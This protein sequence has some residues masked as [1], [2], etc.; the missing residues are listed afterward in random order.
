MC[1]IVGVLS[2]EPVSTDL[3]CTMRDRLEHRG[4]DH[5]GLW[6]S[7][8]SRVSLGHRRL[9]IVDLTPEANQ[10][11]LSHDGRFVI[12]F[13]GEIYNFQELRKEL[14][15]RGARFSTQSDT[16]VLLEAFRCWGDQCLDRLAGMFAFAI[17]DTAERRLFCARDRGGEKPLY[18]TVIDGA[19]VFASELKALVCWP[20]FKR[21]LHYPA[22]LDFL[23]FGYVPDPKSIWE[24]CLKLPP[25]HSLTVKIPPHGRPVISQPVQY[26]DMQFQPEGEHNGWHER[27][28]DVLQRTCKE[29][30]FADVP[31]GA[32]LRGGVDSSSVTAGQ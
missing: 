30:A 6:S 27:I 21:G 18:Y 7:P 25:G 4:P 5:A 1:G 13:N 16:E 19:F 17:W 29:M 2:P 23:A 12:T 31:V 20:G 32:F 15:A 26:W 28:L 22:L 24:D 10:P 9:A 3:V 11:F 14:L 8:D